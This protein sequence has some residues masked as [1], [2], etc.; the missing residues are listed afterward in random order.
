MN[1]DRSNGAATETLKQAG[2]LISPETFEL[3][4]QP[5]LNIDLLQWVERSFPHNFNYRAILRYGIEHLG[6]QWR[7]V[8]VKNVVDFPPRSPDGE[9]IVLELRLHD[10]LMRLQKKIAG[11]PLAP[12][13]FSA[14]RNNTFSVAK[15]VPVDIQNGTGEAVKNVLM[16][17]KRGDSK[18]K[19]MFETF[20]ES[21]FFLHK[22]SP[23]EK[24][25]G[26]AVVRHLFTRVVIVRKNFSEDETKNFNVSV[27]LLELFSYSPRGDERFNMRDFLRDLATALFT[28]TKQAAEIRF[29]SRDRYTLLLFEESVV[30][31]APKEPGW[32]PVRN[33]TRIQRTSHC[34]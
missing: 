9:F 24:A 11:M 5:E 30:N 29:I 22:F 32:K 23:E 10:M 1:A 8:N 12:I 7:A 13:I 27:P 26:T 17:E 15:K 25:M 2:P 19:H 21:D 34:D 3:E 6:N 33:N 14:F 16:H 18:I 28:D 31:L 4:K 20:L